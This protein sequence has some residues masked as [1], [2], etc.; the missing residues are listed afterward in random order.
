MSNIDPSNMF[1]DVSA[2]AQAAGGLI[3]G[4][5]VRKLDSLNLYNAI[6]IATPESL[7]VVDLPVRV[8]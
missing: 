8:S 4:A 2:V 5:L 7:P 1:G 3:L 6:L